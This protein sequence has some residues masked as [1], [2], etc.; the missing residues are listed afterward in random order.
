MVKCLKLRIVR[1]K[2][3][4]FFFFFAKSSAVEMESCWGNCLMFGSSLSRKLGMSANQVIGP[5][6]ILASWFNLVV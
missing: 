3:K 5:E 1:A 2:Q 6:N 4:S